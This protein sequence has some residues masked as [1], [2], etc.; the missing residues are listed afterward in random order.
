MD[1]AYSNA[2]ARRDTL[3]AQ[4]NKLQQ[5]LDEARSALARVDAFL[6]DWAEFAGEPAPT[7][8]VKSGDTP[9]GKLRILP[10][11]RPKNPSKEEVIE[12]VLE[13]LHERGRPMSRSDLFTA[14]QERGVVLEGSDPQMVLSTMLWRMRGK[15]V[16]LPKNIGYWDAALSYEPADYIGRNEAKAKYL[17]YTAKLAPAREAYHNGH[18]YM[19]DETYDSLKRAVEAIEAAFPDITPTIFD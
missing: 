9:T 17:E 16:R 18:P 14:L 6:R 12:S 1:A 2:T 8:P 15:V 19:S 3:A 7:P 13:I 5:E 11:P 10:K 4:I